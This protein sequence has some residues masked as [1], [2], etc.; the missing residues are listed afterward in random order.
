MTPSE[1]YERLERALKRGYHLSSFL[2]DLDMMRVATLVS[3]DNTMITYHAS[4]ESIEEA[5]DSLARYSSEC[6]ADKI[7]PILWVLNMELDCLALPEPD[8][9]PGAPPW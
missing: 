6:P 4:E 2:R 1:R 8:Y 9:T 5:I 7:E 3:F